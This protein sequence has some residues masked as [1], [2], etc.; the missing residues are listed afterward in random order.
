MEERIYINNM[1]DLVAYLA[2]ETTV[3][4][5]IVEYHPRPV[6]NT[7]QLSGQVLLWGL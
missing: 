3:E 4:S 2:P 7:W 6:P 5:T 1:Q